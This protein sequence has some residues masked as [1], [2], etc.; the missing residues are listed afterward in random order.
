MGWGGRWGCNTEFIINPWG[1]TDVLVYVSDALM[2]GACVGMFIGHFDG[3]SYVATDQQVS[4]LVNEYSQRARG[5]FT[6]GDLQ[7]AK[8]VCCLKLICVVKVGHG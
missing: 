7:F 5:E 6:T 2:A 4:T 3:F 1:T 8:A